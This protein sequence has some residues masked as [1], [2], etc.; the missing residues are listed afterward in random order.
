M[1][2][3]V[4]NTVFVQGGGLEGSLRCRWSHK[5]VDF[6]VGKCCL[7]DPHFIRRRREINKAAPIESSRENRLV[8]RTS[9]VWNSANGQQRL[10]PCL[11]ALLFP[12]KEKAACGR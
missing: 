11:R 12:Q 4:D 6:P 7:R 2:S 9:R 5:Q 3:E 8:Q 1:N 10:A